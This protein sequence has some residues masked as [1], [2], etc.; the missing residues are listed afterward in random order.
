VGEAIYKKGSMLVIR[1]GK[2]ENNESPEV[3]SSRIL[4]ISVITFSIGISLA[5]KIV[6]GVILGIKPLFLTAGLFLGGIAVFSAILGKL[7]FEENLSSFQIVGII[8]IAIGVFT[9]V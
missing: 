2:S 7:L 4:I 3:S 9:L 6:Y 8:F 1:E 5:V